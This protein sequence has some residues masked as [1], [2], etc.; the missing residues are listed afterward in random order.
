[1]GDGKVQVARGTAIPVARWT[2]LGPNWVEDHF[3]LRIKE[4]P[5]FFLGAE[6]LSE[7]YT[8]LK[9]AVDAYLATL[10]GQLSDIIPP[11]NLLRWQVTPMLRVDGGSSQIAGG[12]LQSTGAIASATQRLVSQLA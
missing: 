9:P 8:E 1:M 11:E 6:T 12:Q 7:L 5:D 2:F 10:E 4:L 3:E